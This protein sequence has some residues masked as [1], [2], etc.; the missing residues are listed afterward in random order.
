V[1][2]FDPNSSTYVVDGDGGV[3]TA[4]DDPQLVKV[5]KRR[6]SEVPQL[7]VVTLPLKLSDHDNRKH[8]IVLVETPHRV[9]IAE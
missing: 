6:T 4:V 2:Q 3:K 7:V 8:H 5:T 9:R 1:I